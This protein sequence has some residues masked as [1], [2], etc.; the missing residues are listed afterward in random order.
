MLNFNKLP[1]IPFLPMNEILHCLK[2]YGEH[3][4]SEVAEATGI[5]ISNLNLY[6]AE[7]IDKGQIM[8]VPF[9]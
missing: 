2:K 9:D 6:L 7:L 5:P 4:E 8:N 1:N 3:S